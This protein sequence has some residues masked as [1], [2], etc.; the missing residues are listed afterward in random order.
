MRY[1]FFSKSMHWNLKNP[2]KNSGRQPLHGAFKSRRLRVNIMLPS[3][4]VSSKWS[5]SFR[6]PH[7]NPLCNSLLAHTCCTSC[8]S[9]HPEEICCNYFIGHSWVLNWECWKNESKWNQGLQAIYNYILFFFISNLIHCF[10]S[11]Y[12]ICYPT[13]LY[14]FQASQAHHQEV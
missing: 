11:T 9:H 6:F 4:P 1:D 14:M 12:N 3:M 8:P 2:R 13:F 7:Q 10:P 5:L